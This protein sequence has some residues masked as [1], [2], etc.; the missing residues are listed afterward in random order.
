VITHH[1]SEATVTAYAAGTLSEGLALVVAT[2]LMS[3]PACRGLTRRLEAVGGVML[4][5][6]PPAA[7]APDAL[8]MV[9]ARS[10][11]PLVPPPPRPV[12]PGLPPPLNHCVY[13]KWLQVGLGI[14]WRPMRVGGAAWAGLLQIAPGRSLPRHGHEGPEL[15]CVLSGN[16]TD[17]NGRYEA[18]D[19]AEP[20]GDGDHQPRVDGP[21]SCLCVIASEGMRLRGVLGLA[22]RL[23]R[24]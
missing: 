5:D 9:L 16:F 4:E 21:Q 14:R 18:G 7:M 2:H 23:L 13:G 19:V 6:L 15:A 8:S 3:C 12:E 1:P 20:D 17:A 10:E 24:R 11:R 22:Q